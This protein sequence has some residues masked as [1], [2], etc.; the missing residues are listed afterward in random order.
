MKR[1]LI[2]GLQ[3]CESGPGYFRGGPD[4]FR[5]EPDYLRAKW[6]AVIFPYP[7]NCESGPGLF[8]AE[9]GGDFAPLLGFPF[10]QGDVAEIVGG[11]PVFGALDELKYLFGAGGAG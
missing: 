9:V 3:N 8:A 1:R 10:Q 11:E 7:Q 4:G 6:P 5:G 2:V